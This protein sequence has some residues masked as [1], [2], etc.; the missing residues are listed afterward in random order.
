MSMGVGRLKS[1]DELAQPAIRLVVWKG[2]MPAPRRRPEGIQRG[3]R[4]RIPLVEMVLL[5]P[6]RVR[7]KCNFV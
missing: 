3:A 6:V 2:L 4:Q 1:P 5:D 7:T